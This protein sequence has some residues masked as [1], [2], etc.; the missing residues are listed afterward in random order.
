MPQVVNIRFRTRGK[1]Y[2]FSPSN[3]PLKPGMPVIVDTAKGWEYALCNSAPY[4]IDEDKIVPPLRNVIRIATEQDTQTVENYRLAERQTLAI[5]KRKV[6]EHGLEMKLID[7][8]FSFDGT[9]ITFHFTADGRVDFRELVRDLGSTFHKRIELRQIGIRDGAR[10]LGGLGPCG[11]PFCCSTF[12]TEFQAISVKM[13]KNQ[14]LSL[15]PVK[16]SGAC[17]NLMCCLKHEEEA[18]EELQKDAPLVDSVVDTPIGKGLVVDVNLLRRVAK[19]KVETATETTQKSYPFA[20]L[21]YTINGKYREPSEAP[22]VVEKAPAFVPPTYE[23][24]TQ[25]MIDS[26]A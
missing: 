26:Y 3:L 19:V 20:Q 9:K 10:I 13:A 1:V 7:A 23:P 4:E 11:R 5:C 22:T 21:G 16:I 18:Y 24:H 17:G 6:A 2:Y 25:A 8:D 15:N 12:L 14:S